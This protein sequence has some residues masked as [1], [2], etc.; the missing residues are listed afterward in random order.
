MPTD[1]G[2]TVQATAALRL[3]VSELM[4]ATRKVSLLCND[5]FGLFAHIKK[6]EQTDGFCLLTSTTSAVCVRKRKMS[7]S[8]DRLCGENVNKFRVTSCSFMSMSADKMR[9]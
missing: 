6:T 5:Y 1:H 9:C 8:T 7:L 2:F 4:A 3:Q